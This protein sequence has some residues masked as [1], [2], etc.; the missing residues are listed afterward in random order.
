[1]RRGTEAVIGEWISVAE[2]GEASGIDPNLFSPKLSPSCF[3]SSE[4]EHNVDVRRH[5]DIGYCVQKRE[6]HA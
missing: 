6:P 5:K 4:K 3:L 2:W 1:M